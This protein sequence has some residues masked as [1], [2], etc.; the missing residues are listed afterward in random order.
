[1]DFAFSEEHNLFRN[2][3]RKFA[4]RELAPHY[5][6]HD[7]DKTFPER[8]LKACAELGLLGLRIPEA[9]GGSPHA[10]VASGIAAEECGRADFNVAYFPLMSNS[11]AMSSASR[12]ATGRRRSR[13]SSSAARS[14]AV[15]S[16]RIE[17][18]S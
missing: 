9:M 13:R 4:E 8:Q 16:N 5:Q 12:S 10:Y 11:C 2:A 14:S 6:Q 15:S 7:R 1:M 17:A 18:C 3:V